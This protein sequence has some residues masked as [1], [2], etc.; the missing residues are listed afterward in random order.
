VTKSW[1]AILSTKFPDK[2]FKQLEHPYR[3]FTL[4]DVQDYR[5]FLT[6][7]TWGLEKIF[8]RPSNSRYIAIVEGPGALTRSQLRSSLVCS[9]VGTALI[10][11]V[12]VAFLVWFQIPGAFV[13]F[14]FIISLLASWNSLLNT[15]NLFKIGQDII[16]IKMGRIK[17]RDD[18]PE[19]EEKAEADETQEEEGPPGPEES[20]QDNP[21]GK[22]KFALPPRNHSQYLWDKVGAQPSEAVYLVSEYTR[23]TEATDVFCW[24]MF[25]LEILVFYVYPLTT[26]SDINSSLAVLFVI[27]GTVSA[28]RHY[29]NVTSLIEETGNI[30]LVGGRTDKQKWE[31]KSRLN[32]I[33]GHVTAAKTRRLWVSILGCCGF[34]ILA[35]FLGAVGSST[36]NTN[37]KTFTYLPNFYY[38]PSSD[39]M[40]YPT[41]TLSNMH[42][43]FAENSTL[44][45]FAF[46]SSIAYQV[47]PQSALNSWFNPAGIEAI[48]EAEYVKNF[49]TQADANDVAVF[50]KLFSFPQI[51][52]A[53]IVIRGTS[54]NWDMVS[55]IFV[56]SFSFL[57]IVTKRNSAVVDQLADVQLWSAA[58][59][60]QG[61]RAA[62]PAGGIWTP[63]LSRKFVVVTDVVTVPALTNLVLFLPT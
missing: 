8:C 36:A 17:G 24:L 55:G 1:W 49:R 62:L 4:E 31:N 32:N 28:I 51:K 6:K 12:L 30:N 2:M 5:P 25:P 63:I 13:A 10:I 43:G 27:C 54:N 40:R 39:D 35:V 56:G 37:T 16:D 14:V 29:L 20:W 59:L 15:R 47:N 18:E 3:L 41:C 48:D 50:F 26:L 61:L 9:L 38:P 46:L 42:G 44:A 21:D 7:A 52:F 33:V 45:D 53:M 57:F 11:V 60:M 22:E 34:G 58:S 19:D 23:I